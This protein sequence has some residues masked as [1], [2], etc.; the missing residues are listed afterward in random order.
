ANVDHMA[1]LITIAHGTEG[2]LDA[3]EHHLASPRP[4]V[5][6]ERLAEHSWERRVEAMLAAIDE[7]LEGQDGV[8][9]A[10][11]PNG[12]EGSAGTCRAGPSRPGRDPASVAFRERFVDRRKPQERAQP[13]VPVTPGDVDLQEI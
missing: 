12:C 8:E 7:A 6:A 5:S 4:E 9:A 13:L 1:D 10:D 3:I 2:F 11:K